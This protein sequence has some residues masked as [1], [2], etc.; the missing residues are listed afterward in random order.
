[1]K[2]I[3]RLVMAVVLLATSAVRM[4][5]GAADSSAPGGGGEPKFLA[6]PED[7]HRR[8]G[9]SVVLP[10]RVKNRNGGRVQWTRDDFG[11]GS[12]R[13]TDFPRYSVIGRNNDSKTSYI[14]SSFSPY[15]CHLLNPCLEIRVLAQMPSYEVLDS[16]LDSSSLEKCCF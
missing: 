2:W 16:V 15:P 10:C 4:P 6:E 1:M 14:S 11:L 5:A 8:V 13:T 7:V 9:Q 3:A 12:S